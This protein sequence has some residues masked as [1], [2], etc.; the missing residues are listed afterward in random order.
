MILEQVSEMGMPLSMYGLFED[1]RI[2]AV[3][4]HQGRSA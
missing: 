3:D 2:A 4:P 1:G